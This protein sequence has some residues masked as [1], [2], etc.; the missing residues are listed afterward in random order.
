MLEMCASIQIK[1]PRML[2]DPWITIFR[3]E[4]YA[5]IDEV[6]YRKLL[7]KEGESLLF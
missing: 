3:D 4:V 5:K 7:D 2:K 1:K 6:L